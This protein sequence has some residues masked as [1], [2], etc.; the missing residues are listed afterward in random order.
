MSLNSPYSN[1]SQNYKFILVVLLLRLCSSAIH[2]EPL[3]REVDGVLVPPPPNMV[4]VS[5]FSDTY[6]AMMKAA[7]EGTFG[8]YYLTD[9]FVKLSK[10]ELLFASQNAHARRSEFTR[11][12]AEDAA[13]TFEKEMNELQR[14]LVKNVLQR[15]AFKNLLKKSLRQT[16]ADLPSIKLQMGGLMVLDVD[17]STPS[18]GSFTCAMQQKMV[19]NGRTWDL[20]IISCN[21]WVRIDRTVIHLIYNA[22]LIDED[23]PTKVKEGMQKW[24]TSIVTKNQR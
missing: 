14:D 4:E 6:R 9:E 13:L 23:T 7:P 24:I 22:N 2:S 15:D 1:M 19:A 21:A 5:D 16:E 11:A 17:V 20:T 8:L 12:T 10:G 18:Q 3:S